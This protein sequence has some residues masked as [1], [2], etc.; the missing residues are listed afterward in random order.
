MATMTTVFFYMI[1]AYT[2]T[3][4]SKVLALSATAS[5]LV[6]LC[7]GLTNFAM[8]PVMGALSD[9]IGRRPLLLGATNGG[10]RAWLSNYGL[11]GK[12]AFVRAV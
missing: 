2:P 9:R 1:T 5:L 11:V 8:L 10:N 6:T 12:R 7:V 4:G 3:Y